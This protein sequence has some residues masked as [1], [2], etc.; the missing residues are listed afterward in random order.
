MTIREIQHRLQTPLGTER[1]HETI[2]N[3]TEAVAGEAQGVAGRPSGPGLADRLP[4]RRVGR[5]VHDGH[6]VRNK[7]APY[8]CRCRLRRIKHVLGI[9]VQA[10]ERAEFWA[11]VCAELANRACGTF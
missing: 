4:R 3:I 10:T 7:A 9:W 2:S 5:K 11:A 6:Q 8:R 1:S